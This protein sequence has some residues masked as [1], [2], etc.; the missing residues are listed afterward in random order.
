MI[1]GCECEEIQEGTAKDAVGV[2]GAIVE[3][4][5]VVA[6]VIVVHVVAEGG[7]G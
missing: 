6:E 5:A 3:T 7:N 2:V 4:R 1:L